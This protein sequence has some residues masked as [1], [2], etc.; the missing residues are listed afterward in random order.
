MNKFLLLVVVAFMYGYTDSAAQQRSSSQGFNI[1]AYLNGSAL[2]AE[3]SNE[4]D[5]GGGFGLRLGYGFSRLLEGFA[6]FQAASMSEDGQSYNLG[7]FDLGARFNF[8]NDLM[9]LRPFA[10]LALNGRAMSADI[11][12]QTLESRGAG[13]TLGGG[14]KYFFSPKLALDGG[15]RITVGEF[16][17]GRYGGGSWLDFGDE[18][19]SSTTTRLNVGVSYFF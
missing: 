5:N 7:H 19:F 1:G 6:D 10:E 14:V 13:L 17:E 2:S 15:L 11:M 4:V 9:A 16:S 8:G 18:A 12:G 3:G